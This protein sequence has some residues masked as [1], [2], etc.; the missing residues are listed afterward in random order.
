ML[1]IEGAIISALLS[2]SLQVLFD[3]IS[4][5]TNLCEFLQRHKFDEILLEKLETTMLQVNAV[6]GNAEEKQI[7]N[8]FVRQWLEE[9]KDTA[10]HTVDLLDEIYSLAFA[11]CQA[12]DSP[13]LKKKVQNH[14][15]KLQEM[16]NKLDDIA[17]H[18]DVLGLEASFSGKTSPRLQLTSLVDETEFA[19]GE[20]CFKFERGKPSGTSKKARHFSYVRDHFDGLEKFDALGEAKFLWT[21]L[22]LSLSIHGGSCSI[23]M[24][25]VDEYL[26]RQKRLRVLSLSHY[27]NINMLPKKFG[28]LLHLR[29][30][31]LSHTAIGE[32]PSSVGYLYNLQTILLTHCILLVRLP[33]NM[34]NLINLGHL[35]LNGTNSLRMMPP[36]FGRLKSLRILTTFVVS[37]EGS[38]IKELGGL[39]HL[40]GKLS[41]LQL[42]KVRGAEDAENADLKNK[43]NI[44]ELEFSWSST[45]LADGETTILEKLHPHENIEK[46]SIRGNCSSLPSLGQLSSLQELH[47]KNMLVLESIHVEFYGNAVIPFA[48]LCILKFEDMPKWINW[49]ALTD[50]GGG[51]P[52]LQELHIR[53]CDYLI[54]IPN[55]L[56]LLE[57]LFI[58]ECWQLQFQDF[59][60]YPALQTLHIESCNYPMNFTLNFFSNLKFL[61]IQDCRYLRFLEI[62]E[63]LHHQELSFFQ[64][65]E[66]SECPNMELFSGR[67]LP[68][69]NLT[70][71]SISNGNNLRS[72]P[73]QMHM[74]LSSLQTLNISGC[75]KLVSFPDG[76]LPPSLQIL[77]IKNCVNLTP[78]NSW[79]LRNL[80][81]LT[82]LTIE[83]AYANVTSFPDEGLLP[84]SLTFLQIS[85]FP[86]LQTLNLSG[87]QHLTML[88][89]LQIH[90]CN[91]LQILSDGSLPTSLSSLT[92]TGFPSLTDLC[93]GIYWDKISHITYTFINGNQIR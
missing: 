43:K 9:L 70:T 51:F 22:P 49:S 47:V 37:Q 84:A 18:K 21:F 3:R 1:F 83:C 86:V 66:I 4:P 7:T 61:Q 10:Y 46:L 16:I 89:D 91:Q 72:M 71:F 63:E 34:R 50:T 28:K 92:I 87:L 6:L 69:P 54:E 35:D 36:E 8:L 17:K 20:S 88:K 24:T 73:E 90:S 27:G 79:G 14:K 30:L 11:E 38:S 53:K 31:D 76:G 75:P 26:P 57:L 12:I 60:D 33:D 67:G 40:G 77:T 81:S 62:S 80:E 25:V 23:N 5:R 68:A 82:C 52:S 32:L 39:L 15:T 2:A 13:A 45:G 55:C 78:Q 64:E 44:K 56:P 42:Q 65:L 48:S 29:Y 41:I 93:Q 19:S 58:S 85:E 74:L 59:I